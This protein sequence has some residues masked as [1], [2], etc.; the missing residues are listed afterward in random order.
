MGKAKEAKVCTV[1]FPAYRIRRNVKK[2]TGKKMGIP[3]AEVMGNAMCNIVCEL[4]DLA[5]SIKFK[6]GERALKERITPRKVYLAINRDLEFYNQFHD[7]LVREGGGTQHVHKALT[8][9]KG[10]Y[11][12]NDPEK[13]GLKR[14]RRT[15]RSKGPGK[16]KVTKKTQKKAAK[17]KGAKKGKK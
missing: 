12:L 3:A 10:E 1:R 13:A 17:G 14:R 15:G 9:K 8:Y 5:G 4:L 16:S 2:M 6:K 7:V 11:K